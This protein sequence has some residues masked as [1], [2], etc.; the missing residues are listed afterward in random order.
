M[1]LV[2]KELYRTSRNPSKL[3]SD[4]ADLGEENEKDLW[5]DHD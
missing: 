1:A 5:I 4:E 2:D 3:G